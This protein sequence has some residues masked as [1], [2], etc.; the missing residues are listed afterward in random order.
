M[1]GVT[2][3]INVCCFETEKAAGMPKFEQSYDIAIILW[4][5]R[6]KQLPATAGLVNNETARRFRV[7]MVFAY[8]GDQ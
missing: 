6:G 2:I 8:Q 4:L 7:G 3:A 1:L 5:T